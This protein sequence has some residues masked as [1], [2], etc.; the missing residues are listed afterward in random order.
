MLINR[1][2]KPDNEMDYQEENELN[3]EVK[4]KKHDGKKDFSC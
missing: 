2:F 1:N 4:Y 3:N